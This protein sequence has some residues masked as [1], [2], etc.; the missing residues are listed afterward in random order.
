MTGELLER[1]DL[2]GVQADE[3]VLAMRS[4]CVLAQ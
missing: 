4:S 2:E 1:T 3:F